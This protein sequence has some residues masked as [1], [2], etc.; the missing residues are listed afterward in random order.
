MVSPRGDMNNRKAMM[1]GMGL[2]NKDGHKRITKGENFVIAGG[3]EETH[4]RMAET[5]IKVNEKL[6]KRGKRLEECSAKEFSDIVQES[7]PK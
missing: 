4:D 7:T 2:D 5:V 1:L 3:S 6:S